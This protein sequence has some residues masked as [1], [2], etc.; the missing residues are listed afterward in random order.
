MKKLLIFLPIL[1]ISFISCKKNSD[2]IAPVITLNGASSLVT[3]KGYPYSDQGATASD[4][5]DGDITSKIIINNPV[6][7]GA[8]GIYYVTFNVSDDAG[9]AAIEVKRKVEVKYL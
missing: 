4:D 7:T 6:D 3:G 1:L 5:I 8:I 2:K 9:N